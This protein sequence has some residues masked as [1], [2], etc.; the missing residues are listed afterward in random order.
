MKQ[1]NA[2]RR[3]NEQAREV[4]AHILLFEVSDPRLDMV[5]ITGCEVSYD[6]SY[7]NVYYTAQPGHYDDAREG[8]AAAAGRIRTLMGGQIHWRVT[9]HLRFI[10]DESVDEA[11]R[12][13]VALAADAERN[14]D[15]EAKNAAREAEQKAALASAAGEASGSAAEG[16][17]SQDETS[18]T[19]DD[20][21]QANAVHRADA[22]GDEESGDWDDFDEE[23]AQ[24]RAAQNEGD[25][26][27]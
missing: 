27:R 22:E 4:L 10:L 20:G 19:L 16:D 24:I 11:E 21:R 7:C 15:S 18:G 14:A 17:G 5:T 6:R 26:V 1:S 12:I 13:A 23:L 9:P 25:D 3:I 8:F 2:N